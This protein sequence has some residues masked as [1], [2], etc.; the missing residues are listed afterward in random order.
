MRGH[1]V[2]IQ[3]IQIGELSGGI[4]TMAKY[5][6]LERYLG[7]K[8]A[9]DLSANGERE[10]QETIEEGRE[11]IYGSMDV[12]SMFNKV[13]LIINDMLPSRAV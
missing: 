12:L 8:Y 3:K 7:S 13:N 2:S 4:N 11:I 5:G 6:D 1:V 10:L 9:Q